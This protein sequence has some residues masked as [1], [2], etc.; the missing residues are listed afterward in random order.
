MSKFLTR[1][2]CSCKVRDLYSAPEELLCLN[3]FD[4]GVNLFFYFKLCLSNKCVFN[5]FQI[6]IISSSELEV[7]AMEVQKCEKVKEMAEA[8]RT[9]IVHQQ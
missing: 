4:N 5:F 6:A 8:F 9:L 3:C 2:V 1:G 7:I